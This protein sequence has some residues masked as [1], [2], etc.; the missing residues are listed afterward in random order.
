[1]GDGGV[2]WKTEKCD[3]VAAD[4]AYGELGEKVAARCHWNVL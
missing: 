4:D 2:D 3:E 1:M